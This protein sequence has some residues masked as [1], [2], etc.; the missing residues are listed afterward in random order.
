MKLF[1]IFAFERGACCIQ[2]EDDGLMKFGCVGGSVFFLKD[3]HVWVCSVLFQALSLFCLFFSCCGQA[4]FDR[5]LGL[6]Y[7]FLFLWS[8]SIFC[9]MIVFRHGV[10]LQG[11]DKE[12]VFGWDPTRAILLL[13]LLRQLPL[14]PWRDETQA[15]IMSLLKYVECLEWFHVSFYYLFT[16]YCSDHCPWSLYKWWTIEYCCFVC[17][18]KLR[19]LHKLLLWR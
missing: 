2:M 11:L 13:W 12:F 18:E 6:Y 15:M 16:F 10:M 7:E 9:F 4:L 1:C 8:C 5:N 17:G 19:E 3:T 14:I